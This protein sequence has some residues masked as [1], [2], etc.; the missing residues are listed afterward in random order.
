MGER[1][2]GRSAWSCLVEGQDHAGFI[3]CPTSINSYGWRLFSA[4]DNHSELFRAVP[5]RDPP[6]A[7]RSLTELTFCSGPSTTLPDNNPVP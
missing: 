4:H 1:R 3:T 7:R 6:T 2:K 5:D